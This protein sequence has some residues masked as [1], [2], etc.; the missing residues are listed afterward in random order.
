MPFNLDYDADYYKLIDKDSQEKQKIQKLFYEKYGFQISGLEVET[1]SGISGIN[2]IFVPCKANEFVNNQSKYAFLEKKDIKNSTI[3]PEIIKKKFAQ[4]STSFRYLFSYLYG[5]LIT[6]DGKLVFPKNESYIMGFDLPVIIKKEEQ[7]G[8]TSQ[9]TNPDLKFSII[10]NRTIMS[11]SGVKGNC[12]VVKAERNTLGLPE[13]KYVKERV[14]SNSSII[15]W[16]EIYSNEFVDKGNKY[17]YTYRIIILPYSSE[18][19][20]EEKCKIFSLGEF[21][22]FLGNVE[23]ATNSE[24]GLQAKIPD[25]VAKEDLLHF[26]QHLDFTM[27]SYW[28]EVV[29]SLYTAEINEEIAR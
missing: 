8:F 19:L 28:L 16:K 20:N 26:A 14:K 17:S 7:K 12:T 13:K 9:G 1:L 6:A 21:C 15:K 2:T 27:L 4:Q 11:I 24:T 29:K 18:K 10:L 22:E 23:S 5:V 3:L 25:I